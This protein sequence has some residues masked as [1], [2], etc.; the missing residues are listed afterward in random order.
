MFFLF[1]IGQG[2]MNI[3]NR[4][5]QPYNQTTD[6]HKNKE[7]KPRN[8]KDVCK[9]N[10]YTKTHNRAKLAQKITVCMIATG[11]LP[12]KNESD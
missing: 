11:I 8:W 10:G 7:S 4:A 6:N 12:D 9:Q 1:L 2:F 3:F 5:K